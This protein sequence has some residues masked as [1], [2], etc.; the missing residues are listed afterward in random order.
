MRDADTYSCGRS[1]KSP[2]RGCLNSPASISCETKFLKVSTLEYGKY[3]LTR[4]EA[5]MLL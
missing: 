2:V 1:S 3:G 4:S 5:I